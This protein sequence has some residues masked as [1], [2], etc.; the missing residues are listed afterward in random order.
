MEAV[1]QKS[2]HQANQQAPHAHFNKY[3]QGV[4]ALKREEE[5]DAQQ[6]C[7]HQHALQALYTYQFELESHPDKSTFQQIVEQHRQNC[8]G[9][10]AGNAKK[11]NHHIIGSKRNQREKNDGNKAEPIER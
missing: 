6:T 11:R 9:S 4:A 3:P 5:S 8:A 2:V 1:N 10:S 7:N